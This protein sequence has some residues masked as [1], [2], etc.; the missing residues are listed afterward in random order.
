MSI[1]LCCDLADRLNCF[2]CAAVFRNLLGPRQSRRVAT[3]LSLESSCA[4]FDR[5]LVLERHVSS[6]VP[7]RRAQLTVPHS[8]S[9]RRTLHSSRSSSLYSYSRAF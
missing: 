6:A 3:L 2:N 8:S 9:D 5:L 4:L 1:C 7:H